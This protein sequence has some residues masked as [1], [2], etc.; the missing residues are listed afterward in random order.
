MVFLYS[1]IINNP[2]PFPPPRDHSTTLGLCIYTH[3]FSSLVVDFFNYV[4]T[5]LL[6]AFKTLIK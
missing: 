3:L 5:Y 1:E 4:C 6:V 2:F